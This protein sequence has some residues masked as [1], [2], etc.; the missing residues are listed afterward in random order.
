[1]K[2]FETTTTRDTKT[3]GI[4]KYINMRNNETNKQAK[5]T[6]LKG[7]VNLLHKKAKQA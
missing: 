2:K 3:H 7:E 4:T 1:M 6:H 5:H